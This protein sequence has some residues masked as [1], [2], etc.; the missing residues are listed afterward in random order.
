MLS[1][2]E[3]LGSVETVSII[4]R[5]DAEIAEEIYFS[6]AA[7]SGQGKQAYG[8]ARTPL[9]EDQV[10]HILSYPHGGLGFFNSGI[11]RH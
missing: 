3:Q 9:L 7:R 11:S 10:P 6:L 1:I 2:C 4:H 5:R 8:S